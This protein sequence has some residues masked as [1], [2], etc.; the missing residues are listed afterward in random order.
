MS[1]PNRAELDSAF[2]SGRMT[3]A[4][5]A[6]QL[7]MSPACLNRYI[8]KG[9]L[10]TVTVDGRN[11]VRRDDLNAFESDWKRNRDV[12]RARARA[13]GQVVRR[14]L[15]EGM[16][17][18]ADAARQL[19]VVAKT[20]SDHIN[21]GNLSVVVVD[22]HRLVRRE[23]LEAFKAAKAARATP[24]GMLTLSDVARELDVTRQ[25]AHQYLNKGQLG[26]VQIDGR[27]LVRR[28]ELDA[29]M[30]NR[31]AVA[32]ALKNGLLTMKDVAQASG[33]AQITVQ[34]WVRTG[35]LASVK[36]GG[37][38]LIRREDLDVF[39]Q[40]P[41]AHTGPKPKVHIEQTC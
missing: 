35:R 7:G 41:Q 4:A 20:V 34:Q 3:K 16:L 25:R 30:Q 10:A 29:F 26:T 21:R 40:K 19:G 28:E 24:A 31:A 15:A 9:R 13:Q 1:R 38:R 6:R 5:A 32:A 2:S 17:T 39:M 8:A 18:Q 36:V 14:A 33:Y 22:G 27:R 12:D 11:W 23:D 37:R